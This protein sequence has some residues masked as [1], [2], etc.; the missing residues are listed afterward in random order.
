MADVFAL[1]EPYSD[2]DGYWLGRFSTL[3]GEAAKDADGFWRGQFRTTIREFVAS[4]VPS[5]ELKQSLRE[6]LR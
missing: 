5:D 1:I 2:T 3:L 6:Y 4:P